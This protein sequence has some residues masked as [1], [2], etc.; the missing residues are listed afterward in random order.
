MYLLSLEAGASGKAISVIFCTFMESGKQHLDY[1]GAVG[2]RSK[3][4]VFTR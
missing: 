1:A 4:F 3:P 2:M